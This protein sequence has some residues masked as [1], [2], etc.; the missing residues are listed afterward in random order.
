MNRLGLPLVIALLAGVSGVAQAQYILQHYYCPPGFPRTTPDSDFLDSGNGTVRHLATGLIWKRCGEGQVWSGGFCHGEF[1]LLTWSQAF[2]RVDQVNRSPAPPTVWNAGETDWRMPNVN[3]L[4]SIVER[5]CALPAIN[6][7]Q[8][9]NTHGSLFWASSPTTGVS[10][11][12]WTVGFF[13]GGV[14]GFNRNRGGLGY[15]RLVRGGKTHGAFDAL[16][17]RAPTLGTVTSGN[18]VANVSFT[19]AS[20]GPVANAYT[21]TC[22]G[23]GT[24]RMV[25]GTNSPIR[26]TS[27]VNGVTYACS[28][29]AGNAEGN[30]LASGTANVVPAPT[31]PGVPTLLRLIPGD[32]SMKVLFSPPADNGGAAITG[33]EASC[34]GS[35]GVHF[36]PIGSQSPLT[37]G[38]LAKGLSYTCSIKAINGIGV[39]SASAVLTRIARRISIV[40]ILN[41]IVE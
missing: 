1:Q 32:N 31:V 33:Y 8:F 3:E 12:A 38:G 9:P 23:N 28:V 39:S 17:P 18:T 21:A 13:V 24:T 35:D 30:S 34:Q 36:S 41:I 27:L 2:D 7:T 5:G 37:V 29:T 19:P 6:L 10:G 14:T 4:E 26:V 25:I 16:A 15:L 11:D 20:S 40:P 22:T